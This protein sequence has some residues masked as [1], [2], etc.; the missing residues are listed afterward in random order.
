MITMGILDIP[1]SPGRATQMNE[2]VTEDGQFA[3]RSEL[4]GG[5]GL[6]WVAR[7]A[8]PGALYRASVSAQTFETVGGS[9]VNPPD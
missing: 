4:G 6:M 9:V 8:M 5:G 3:L 7:I 2:P 1:I